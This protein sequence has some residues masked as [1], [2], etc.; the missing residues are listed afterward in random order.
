MKYLWLFMLILFLFSGN[1]IS[2]TMDSVEIGSIYGQVVESQAKEIHPDEVINKKQI[3]L[4]DALIITL[5]KNPQLLA[6]SLQVRSMDAEV[7]QASFLP[8]PELD[9]ELE[10]F[11]GQNEV[12]GFKSTETTI[13]LGQLLE[14]GGKRGKRTK[15]AKIGVLGSKA[16][17]EAVKLMIF[18]EVT[19]A[20]VRVLTAQEQLKLQKEL[21]SL[22][23]NFVVS[24]QKRVEAGKVSPAEL[25]RAKVSLARTRLE[26][27]RMQNELH[28]ARKNLVRLWGM[29]QVPFDSVTGELGQLITLPDLQDIESEV[30]AHPMIVSQMFRIKQNEAIYELEKSRRIPNVNISFGVRRMNESGNQALVASISMP[31]MIF[32]RNQGM[33][34]RAKIQKDIATVEYKRAILDMKTKIYQMYQSIKWLQKEIKNYQTGIIPS[35][36][37]SFRIITKGYEVGRFTSLDVLDAQRTLFEVKS[38]YLN[39]LAEYQIILG[40][41]ESITG[42]PLNSL[43]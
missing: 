43:K 30:E 33:I 26:F 4:K 42:R 19:D 21:V 2:Q 35:A 11:A 24:I 28:I 13:Q 8:N 31:V 16:D 6:Y 5:L 3:S 39:R 7:L 12:S 32:N 36:E 25:A 1:A 29:T 27:G 23:E 37:M 10:N 38:E 9:V 40:N 15:V 41:L 14:L 22:A 18:A 34:E 17:Y 20:F